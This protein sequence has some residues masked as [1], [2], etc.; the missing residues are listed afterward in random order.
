M[1]FASELLEKVEN[2][3]LGKAD[4]DI[5]SYSI[6]GRDLK[7]Y[8]FSEL[9]KLRDKLKREIEAEKRLKSKGFNKI[10]VRF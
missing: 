10:I 8:S 4:S 9:M 3:L 6:A 1:S 5:E 2:L 7:K